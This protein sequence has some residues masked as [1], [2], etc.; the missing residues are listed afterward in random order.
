VVEAA[1]VEL[2]HN[3]HFLTAES[4]KVSKDSKVSFAGVIVRISYTDFSPKC[5]GRNFRRLHYSDA[6]Y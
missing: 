4:K 3:P 6:F 1:G 5:T 2:I